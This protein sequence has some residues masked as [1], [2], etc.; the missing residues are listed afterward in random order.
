MLANLSVMERIPEPEKMTDEEENFYALADYAKPHDIFVAHVI[1]TVGK[2]TTKKAVDLG[3][4]PGD[5]LLRL[6]KRIPWDLWGVDMSPGML[7]IASEQAANQ[8]HDSHFP[9]NWVLSDIKKTGLPT[10]FFDIIISNSVL[11]HLENPLLFWREI[12]RIAK[13]NAFIFIRD[14]RRPKTAIE[15]DNIVTQHVGNESSIVQIHYR[16]SL[17]SAY[18][19]AE[20]NQQLAE[21]GLKGL[22]VRELEDRYLD[23]YG[24]LVRD[25]E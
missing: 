2:D 25:H 13:P 22:H 18:T 11:H 17:Q 8:L 9:I 12:K 21:V 24:Q 14:L 5:I 6:R 16:S 19:V 15:A 10:H 4:G 20:I 23:I 3:C 7:K 1:D